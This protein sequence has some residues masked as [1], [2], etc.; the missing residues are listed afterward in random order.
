MFWEL[1]HCKTW[2]GES[3]VYAPTFVNIDL[4]YHYLKDALKREVVVLHDV[5]SAENPADMFTKIL[6]LKILKHLTR[7]IGSSYN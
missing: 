1:V 7:I 2:Q 3:V 6:D 4:K 5:I